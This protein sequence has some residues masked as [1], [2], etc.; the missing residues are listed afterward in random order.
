MRAWES[1]SPEATRRLGAEVLTCLGAKAVLLL[2][3]DLGAGKTCL[4]QGLADALFLEEPVTSPTY[5]LVKEY[6]TPPKL[7]HA[8]LYRLTVPEEVWDLELERFWQQELILA[9]EWPERARGIWP[10]HTWCLRITPDPHQEQVRR[11]DL[12]QGE[13]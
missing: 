5:G 9:V 10:D 13:G 4:V 2:Q 11:L 8:D 6:G 3:G 12:M 1:T 7:V